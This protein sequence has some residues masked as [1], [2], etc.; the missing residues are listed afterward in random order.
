M[1][2]KVRILALISLVSANI[3]VP[4]ILSADCCKYCGYGST[5]IES[6]RADATCLFF[7]GFDQCDQMHSS[8]P[9]CQ[10]GSFA[11]ADVY[12]DVCDSY[13]ECAP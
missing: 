3:L 5:I 4:R 7:C 2:S 13:N 6:S 12:D 10:G 8:S 9:N 1:K 11:C